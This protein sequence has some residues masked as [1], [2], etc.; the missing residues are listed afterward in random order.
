M[1]SGITLYIQINSNSGLFYFA[2]SPKW[3]NERVM[4]CEP[5]SIAFKKMFLAPGSKS[6]PPKDIFLRPCPKRIIFR[7]IADSVSPVDTLFIGSWLRL[8]IGFPEQQDPMKSLLQRDMDV[9]TRV[10]QVRKTNSRHFFPGAPGQI[11]KK[12]LFLF[13]GRLMRQSVEIAVKNKILEHCRGWCF[14]VMNFDSLGSGD[15]I[16]N[17]L[18]LLHQQKVIR[19]LAQGIF[20]Y[21]KEHKDLGIIPPD[22]NEVGKAIAAKNGVRIQPSGAHAANLVGLSEQVP[23]FEWVELG[24]SSC[25]VI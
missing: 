15:S 1:E 8:K 13:K 24:D 23:V 6:Q 14:T 21:P 9:P 4:G 17:A 22:L 7:S 2:V 20:D 19:R 25:H 11:D 10:G 18:W 5:L 16:R 3:S 12:L